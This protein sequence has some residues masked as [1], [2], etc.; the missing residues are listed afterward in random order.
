MAPPVPSACSHV[1]ASPAPQILDL[2]GALELSLSRGRRKE[3]VGRGSAPSGLLP[4]PW[5]TWAGRSSRVL[6][7]P[8]CASRLGVPEG[9]S[10]SIR[11]GR[12]HLIVTLCETS[13]SE[14]LW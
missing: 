13:P 9:A 7:L 4:N 12:Y 8:L 14:T 11:E 6:T 3:G 2:L 10:A 1:R 5:R